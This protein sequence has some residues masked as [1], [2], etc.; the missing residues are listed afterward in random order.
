MNMQ[1]L[2]AMAIALAG[3]T[4]VLAQTPATAMELA[5]HRAEAY[6]KVLALEPG[7]TEALNALFVAGEKD[8]IEMRLQCAE[9]QARINEKIQGQEEGLE[10]ILSKKQ[11]MDLQALRSSGAFDPVKEI[12]CSGVI[13]PDCCKADTKK[14][15]EAPRMNSLTPANT[16]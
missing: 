1:N 13:T 12:S 15:A 7:Q 3:P 6:A 9:L 11:Y 14:K 8:L 4:M 2:I 10:H 5:T 16:K